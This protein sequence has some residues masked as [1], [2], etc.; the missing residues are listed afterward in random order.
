[1]DIWTALSCCVAAVVTGSRL[2]VDWADRAQQDL[3]KALL[4]KDEQAFSWFVK[5]NW[6]GMMRVARSILGNESLAA[7]VVQETWETVLKELGKFRGE[8]SINTWM[9][10][11]LINRAKRVGARE[12]RRL[13]GIDGWFCD[14]RRWCVD[15]GAVAG[16][17]RGYFRRRWCVRR[18][19]DERDKREA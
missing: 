2:A 3:V 11:I 9:F 19:V 5:K 17:H 6:P 8:S 10:R 13:A 4:A 12:S 1:M 14:D 16:G 18:Y 7:E 15:S